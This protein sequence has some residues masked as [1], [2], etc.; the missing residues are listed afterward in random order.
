MICC[1]K[2]LEKA[3]R[4]EEELN[5]VLTVSEHYNALVCESA[6]FVFFIGDRID[7]VI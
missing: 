7:Y 2:Y 1:I 4:K 6:P 5:V 3:L